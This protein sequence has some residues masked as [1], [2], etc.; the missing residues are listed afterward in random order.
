MIERRWSLRPLTVRDRNA[1]N[2]AEA[3][4]FSRTN[5]RA[6]PYTVPPGPFGTPCGTPSVGEEHWA[7]LLALARSTGWQL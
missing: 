1:N 6:A 2:L 7:G 3:L 4:D 5:L